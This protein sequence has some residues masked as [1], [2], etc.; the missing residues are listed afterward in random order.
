M[1]IFYVIY[2]VLI[3]GPLYSPSLEGGRNND[4]MIAWNSRRKTNSD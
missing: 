2:K 4:L 3:S 1:N